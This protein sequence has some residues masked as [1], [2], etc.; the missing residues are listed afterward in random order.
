[1]RE[2]MSLLGWLFQGL[3]SLKQ[4]FPEFRVDM[5]FWLY[6]MVQNPDQNNKLSWTEVLNKRRGDFYILQMGKQVIIVAHM[7]EGVK[8]IHFCF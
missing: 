4:I 6:G 7:Q 8:P 2:M 5:K 3:Y 1:M